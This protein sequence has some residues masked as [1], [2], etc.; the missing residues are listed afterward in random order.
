MVTQPLGHLSQTQATVVKAINNLGSH[1]VIKSL[2]LSSYP[3]A[4]VNQDLFGKLQAQ[5]TFSS[6]SQAAL[7][8]ENPEANIMTLKEKNNIST[9][10]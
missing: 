4:L 1:K 10:S 2:Y 7:I 8:L 9:V 5:V 6:L 3:V